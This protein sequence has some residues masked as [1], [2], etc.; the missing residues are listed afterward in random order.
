MM[1]TLKSTIAFLVLVVSIPVSLH[2]NGWVPKKNHGFIKLGQNFIFANQFF[3]DNGERSSITSS[4]FFTTS[5]YGEIGITDRLTVGTY[6]PFFRSYING[7]KFTSGRA[8]IEGLEASDFGDIDVFFKYG[9]IKDQP[10]VLSASILFGIPSGTSSGLL[11][12]GDGEFNQ[13]FGLNLGYS[14]PKFPVFLGAGTLFN[15]RTKNFSDE[16]R[17]N[18]EVGYQYKEHTLILKSINTWSLRNGD[19]SAVSGGLFSNDVSYNLL[20][21]ELLL[22]NLFKK[23]GVS[24]NY[25]F[26]LSGENT[27]SNDQF[28]IGVFSKF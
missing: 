19:A 24:F 7:T 25:Y 22:G 6:V 13:S 11:T 8:S 14:L 1:R 15:N 17:F 20:G 21:P 27:I 4:G 18:V 9:L 3:R 10:L 28:G 2:A 23:L 12:S 16:F 5:L 26:T